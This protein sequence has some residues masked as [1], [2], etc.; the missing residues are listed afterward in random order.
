MM[1]D[2]VS[3][4]ERSRELLRQYR[5]PSIGVLVLYSVLLAVVTA[6]SFG[7]G[8]LFLAPPLL[9]GLSMFYLGVYRGE[10]PPFETLFQAFNRYTQALIGVLWMNLWI[11]LWSLLLIIPGIIKAFA[12]SMTP[13]LLADF[14]DLD[15]REALKVSMRITAGHKAEIFIM[16]V[17]FLGWN[18]L[19]AFT[20]GILYIIHVGPYQQLSIAG[21]YESFLEQAI[22]EKKITPAELAGWGAM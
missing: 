12:Y 19:S 9:V 17:S 4:K 8:D 16:Y 20:F 14:P 15:P 2:R 5:G 10:Q 22:E 3:I 21:L 6:V 18:L 13:Y 1:Y 11:F 7:L